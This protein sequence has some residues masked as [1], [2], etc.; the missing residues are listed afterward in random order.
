M[1]TKIDLNKHENMKSGYIENIL[2]WMVMFIGF[3]GLLFFVINYAT[4][5]RVKDNMDAISDYGALRISKDGLTLN[6]T[7]FTNKLNNMKVS[8]IGTIDA[9]LGVDLNCST[10]ADSAYQVIFITRS[11]NTSYK[12]FNNRLTSK[13]VVYNESNSNTVTCT[14]DVTLN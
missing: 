7:Q 10:V 3:A 6:T 12:F 9:T 2:L 5:I 11:T 8:A 1:S 13:R 14:L 4:I